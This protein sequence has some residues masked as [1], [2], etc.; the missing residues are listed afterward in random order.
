MDPATFAPALLITALGMGLVFVAIL[1]LWGLMELLVRLLPARAETPPAP[2]VVAPDVAEL[3]AERERR[4]RAAVTAVAAALAIDAV[5]HAAA[6]EAS[7]WQIA[8]RAQA[9]SR[10]GSY[11]RPRSDAPPPPPRSPQG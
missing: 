1:L 5:P 3:E 6:P 2:V 4:R 8:S 7:R 10:L 11:H 9:V